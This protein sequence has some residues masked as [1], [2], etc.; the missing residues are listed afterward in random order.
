[1]EDGARLHQ[2]LPAVGL[3]DGSTLVAEQDRRRPVKG[4]VE[5]LAERRADGWP[6]V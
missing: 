5:L 2:Q 6:P 4:V 1:M 3:G